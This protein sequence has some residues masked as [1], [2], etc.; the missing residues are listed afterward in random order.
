M[1]V[2]I[3]KMLDKN[4]FGPVTTTS[5][6]GTVSAGMFGHVLAKEDDLHHRAVLVRFP[7]LRE[8]HDGNGIPA[9]TISGARER[10]EY[11]EY[12]GQCWWVSPDLLKPAIMENT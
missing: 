3:G 11:P 12:C 9:Y 7:K 8:G 5:S 4:Y 6:T 10:Q 1:R 2:G